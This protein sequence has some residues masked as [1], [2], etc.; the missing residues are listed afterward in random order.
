MP[1]IPTIILPSSLE[2]FLS[3]GDHTLTCKK[4]CEEEHL[5]NVY[6]VT[7]FNIFKELFCSTTLAAILLSL[8]KINAWQ[9]LCMKNWFSNLQKGH[10]AFFKHIHMS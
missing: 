6:F 9:E 7:N 10:K 5:N 1:L 8:F 2:L 4:E 3:I